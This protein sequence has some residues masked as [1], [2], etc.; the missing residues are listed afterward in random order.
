MTTLIRHT[1]LLCACLVICTNAAHSS[2][3]G[4]L[5]NLRKH[6]NEL[7]KEV[8]K[9]SESKSDAMDQLRDSEQAIS[10]S[11]RKLAKLS[12]QHHTANLVLLGC[13]T[14]YHT[15]HIIAKASGLNHR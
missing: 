14:T 5:E 9:T 8:K 13:A 12:T 7:Q 15:A 2:Q 1:L 6:I 4:E 11:K 3:E 10:N